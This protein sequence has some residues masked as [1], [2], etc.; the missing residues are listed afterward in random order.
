MSD[1]V[2]V[3]VEG[4]YMV[5]SPPG[6]AP[7]V[8]LGYENKM[9]PIY[10]GIGEAIAIG[11]ALHNETTPRPMTH[12]LVISLLKKL[13]AKIDGVVI[14]DL[15]DGIYYA[16]LIVQVDG[17]KKELDARPSDCIALALR[18]DAKIR[19]KKSVIDAA[20]VNKDE[21]KHSIVDL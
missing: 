9:L 17:N 5:P 13:N 20:A 8:M 11:G 21:I 18:A 1:T 15:E 10:V 6:A 19:V 16:R 2:P 12:D 14:D 7:V 3:T 4:V